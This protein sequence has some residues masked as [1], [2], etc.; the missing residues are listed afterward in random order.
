[1]ASPHASSFIC[2]PFTDKNDTERAYKIH[3]YVCIGSATVGVIGALLFLC[4]LL[5]G[6]VKNMITKSQKNILV[7]LA[8]CD[9]LADLGE[10]K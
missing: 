5:C 7:S 9:F 6:N 8:V 3:Y 10:L 2:L 4:Q 1:M